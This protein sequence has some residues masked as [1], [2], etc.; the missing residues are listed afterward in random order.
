MPH[1]AAG[2]VCDSVCVERDA[3]G[4]EQAFGCEGLRGRLKNVG[5]ILESDAF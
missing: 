3:V 1:H 5:R 4:V 2:F